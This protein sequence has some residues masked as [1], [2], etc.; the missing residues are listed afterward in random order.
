M[1]QKLIQI[2]GGNTITSNSSINS[3]SHTDPVAANNSSSVSVVITNNSLPV[4]S[5]ISEQ[6]VGYNQPSAPISFT[7]GDV[8]TS[9]H[10]LVV[11]FSSSNK[12]VI[13]LSGLVMSGA[14]LNRSLQI[15]PGLNQFGN[16]VITIEVSDGTCTSS[17]SFNVE[18]F[19]QSYATFESARIVVGQVDFNTINT[20][21]SRIVAPGPTALP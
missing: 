5:A 6:S 11:A 20:T 1:L 13:P 21:S 9:V 10:D 19:K 17:T 2:R 14:G 16:S 12:T 3:S 4:I 18:V 8:E 7:I 15:T